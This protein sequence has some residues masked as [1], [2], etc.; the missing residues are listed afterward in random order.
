MRHYRSMGAVTSPLELTDT[1]STHVVAEMLQ[2]SVHTVMNLADNGAIKHRR[3][4]ISKPPGERIFL[5]ADV[6]AFAKERNWFINP[7]V[8]V[9]PTPCP[10]S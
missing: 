8:Y 1:M 3:K 10:T 9:E 4:V 7:R 2:I 6:V 5:V